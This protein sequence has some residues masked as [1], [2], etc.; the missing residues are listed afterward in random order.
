[1]QPFYNFVNASFTFTYIEVG[2]ITILIEQKVLYLLSEKYEKWLQSNFMLLHFITESRIWSI[3]EK[4]LIFDLFSYRFKN[5][6]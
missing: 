1:M 5:K 6:A 4:K 2:S 3:K